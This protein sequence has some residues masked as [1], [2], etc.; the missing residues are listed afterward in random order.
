MPTN[1]SPFYHDKC[2]NGIS[3]FESA[4]V[5]LYNDSHYYL[6]MGDFNSRTG[7]L[8]DFEMFENKIDI[9]EEY[10]N[11]FYTFDLPRYSC[12]TY[13][14]AFGR[15][16]LD[17]CKVYFIYIMNGRVGQDKNIG[18]FTYIGINGASVIDYV[19]ASKVLF[20][21]IVDF[22]IEPRT[23]STHLPILLKLQIKSKLTE[24]LNSCSKSQYKQDNFVFSRGSEDLNIYVENIRNY[25]L[26]ALY[27]TSC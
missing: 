17:F 3:L 1:G 24:N 18:D 25:L 5:S 19:L 21:Y 15:D 11:A 20:S 14:S 13:V 4:F 10:E 8:S 27:M 26:I 16:L 12:D 2:L 23:E 7:T 6:L 22:N 9:L